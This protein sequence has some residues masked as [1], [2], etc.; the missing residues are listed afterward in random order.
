MD[1]KRGKKEMKIEANELR[2]EINKLYSEM[3]QIN[4]KCV[5][6]I[7]KKLEE[8]ARSESEFY[9]MLDTL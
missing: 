4:E 3:G 2:K 6:E 1:N 5:E 9:Q 8:K 7:I